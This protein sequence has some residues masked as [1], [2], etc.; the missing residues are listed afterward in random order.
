MAAKSCLL[1][2]EEHKPITILSLDHQEAWRNHM[3]IDYAVV[4]GTEHAHTHAHTHAHKH[5]RGQTPELSCQ[6]C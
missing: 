5:A 2:N 6:T 1:R 4:N 3:Q